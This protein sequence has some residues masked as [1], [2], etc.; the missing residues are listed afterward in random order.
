MF[1]YRMVL[2]SNKTASS[3]V[4]VKSKPANFIYNVIIDISIFPIVKLLKNKKFA[5][6]YTNHIVYIYLWGNCRQTSK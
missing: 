6:T 3:E 4:Y 2:F 1:N 5:M